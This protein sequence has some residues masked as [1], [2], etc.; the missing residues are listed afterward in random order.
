M[1]LFV[2]FI[3]YYKNINIDIPSWFYDNS[4]D[5]LPKLHINYQV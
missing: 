1:D 3:A 5:L 4:L 2:N